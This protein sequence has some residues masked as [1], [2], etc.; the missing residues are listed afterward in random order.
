MHVNVAKI[1]HLTP[2]SEDLHSDYNDAP[3]KRFAVLYRKNCCP[4]IIK[5]D[6]GSTTMRV[7]VIGRKSGRKEKKRE[8][9]FSYVYSPCNGQMLKLAAGV[10]RC[11]HNIQ[12][13]HLSSTDAMRS[14]QET[15]NP[16]PT[17]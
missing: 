11:I 14:E 13:C 8:V 2:P 3:K 15:S 5:E 16:K 10:L 17:N 12:A 7:V 9:V 4:T 1:H 6:F